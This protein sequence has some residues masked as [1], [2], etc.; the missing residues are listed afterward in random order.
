MTTSDTTEIQYDFHTNHEL[1]LD[2]EFYYRKGLSGLINTGNKC[3]SN[4]ILHCLSH[5]LKLTDY[6]L[7]NKLRKDAVECDLSKK[8]EYKAILNYTRLLASQWGFNELINPNTFN[9]NISNYLVKYKNNNQHDSYEYLLDLLNLLHNGLS[10]KINMVISGNVQ[11]ETD[12]LMKESLLYWKQT[13]ENNYSEIINLFNGLTVNLVECSNS[14]CKYQSKIMFE[15]FNSLNIDLDLSNTKTNLLTNCIDNYFKASRIDDWKCEKCSNKGCTKKLNMWTLPNY[16]VI[17]L[18]RFDNNG[19][20]LTNF[21]DFP[22]DDLDLT[23]YVCPIK[24]DP[25][26]Y[27]YSLYAINYHTGDVK[28][29]HYWSSVKNFDNDWY[30][31]NDGNVSRYNKNTDTKLQLVTS[32]A[33]ILFYHRKFIKN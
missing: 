18:K 15:C 24:G 26:N 28:T 33:Y 5:T 10:Y 13:Y 3:Y 9:E 32:D 11:N 22:I 7:S 31:F 25:N 20:K 8:K 1:V 6:F 16:L 23:K 2:K 19:R 21:V 14:N 30:I 12:Y 27:I 4:S 29:G 17:Q